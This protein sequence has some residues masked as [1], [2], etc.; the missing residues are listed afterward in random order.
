M[1]LS[2][3]YRAGYVSEYS[4]VNF[5][6]EF[7]SS[8]PDLW[9]KPES[10][11][12]ADAPTDPVVVVSESEPCDKYRIESHGVDSEEYFE[13]PTTECD[14]FSV[15]VTGIG[16]NEAEAYDDAVERME[17]EYGAKFVS[18]LGLPDFFGD[19]EHTVCENCPKNGEVFGCEDGCVLHYYVSVYFNL[20]SSEV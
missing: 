8:R 20:G 19:D 10:V 11:F 6:E 4:M 7:G 14:V 18:S 1:E 9:C 15:V 2:L 13:S 3:G 12:K 16:S 17:W 5:M